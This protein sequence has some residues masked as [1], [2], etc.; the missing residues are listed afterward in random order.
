M[1]A[2]KKNR[3][4]ISVGDRE[5]LWYVA[6]EYDYFPPTV[7]QDLRA[8]NILSV[9]KQFAVRYYLGQGVPERR[10]ISVMG[11][12]SGESQGARIWRHLRSPDWCPDGVV[13]P[14]VVRSVI[15]WSLDGAAKTEVDYTGAEI[16]PPAAEQE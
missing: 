10:Q 11:A 4:K 7:G 3:R 13:T 15:E 2:S 1:G 16:E 12:E 9:N 14:S 6:E 8:L 5:Y